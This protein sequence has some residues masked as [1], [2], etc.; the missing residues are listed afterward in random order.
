MDFTGNGIQNWFLKEIELFIYYVKRPLRCLLKEIPK[1][2]LF[3]LGFKTPACTQH[4]TQLMFSSLTFFLPPPCPQASFLSPH[5]GGMHSQPKGC[6]QKKNGLFSDID[7]KGGQ[8]S[9]RNHYFLKPQKQGHIFRQ[10]GVWRGCHY[11]KTDFQGFT[12]P[13]QK[14]QGPTILSFSYWSCLK[15]FLNLH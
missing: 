11:F 5:K 1:S 15:F 6:L 7:K 4:M 13:C 3:H 9:C 2:H 12:L 10:M 14:T 8:V